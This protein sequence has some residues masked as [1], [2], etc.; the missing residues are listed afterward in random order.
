VVAFVR[1][2]REAGR[3]AAIEPLQRALERLS[4]SALGPH[5]HYGRRQL[6]LLERLGDAAP[7]Q[8]LS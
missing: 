2:R 1:R 8:P 3:V 5:A 4:A 6:A 7:R